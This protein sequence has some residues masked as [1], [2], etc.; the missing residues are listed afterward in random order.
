MVAVVFP[1]ALATSSGLK[2]TRS[3]ALLEVVV[4]KTS[5]ALPLNTTKLLLFDVAVTSKF[6]LV[7][8]PIRSNFQRS[9]Y[10]SST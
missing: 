5:L 6:V 8:S 7:K 2:V 9:Q 1:F 3:V 10:H 4:Y